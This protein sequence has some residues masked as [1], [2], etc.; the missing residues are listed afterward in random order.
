MTRSYS[1]FPVERDT[2]IGLQR[3]LLL[4]VALS[5]LAGCGNRTPV[6]VVPLATTV[7]PDSGDAK[8]VLFVPGAS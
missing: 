8:V 3:V 5:T 4:L 7:L 6:A 2:M 1:G